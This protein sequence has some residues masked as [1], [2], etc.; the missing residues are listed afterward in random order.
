MSV[1]KFF[2]MKHQ[3]N[4]H[5]HPS[6][7]VSPPMSIH[8][9]RCCEEGYSACPFPAARVRQRVFVAAAAVL[10]RVCRVLCSVPCVCCAVFRAVWFAVSVAVMCALC[11]GQHEDADN[12]CF[13]I[14]FRTKTRGKLCI[15]F[16]FSTKTLCGSAWPI[17]LSGFVVPTWRK[18]SN[19]CNYHAETVIF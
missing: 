17:D 1:L 12:F 3:Q 16:I 11:R 8:A 4:T 5:V 19:I 18:G 9:A 14:I 7:V 13:I 2:A 15:L 6:P 10:V